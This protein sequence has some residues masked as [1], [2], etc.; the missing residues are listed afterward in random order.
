[1]GKSTVAQMLSDMGCAVVD[2]D[3]LARQVVQPG[4]LAL[5][6]I[7]QAFGADCLD[8]R[9]QLRRDHLARLVF[10]DA[11]ARRRLEEILH[12]RIRGLWRGQVEAWRAVGRPAAVVVIPLLFETQAA[13]E[14]DV[15]L[16]VACTS[17]SQRERL[18][19][20]GWDPLEAE[21]RLRAQ[22]PVEQKIARSGFVVWT[23]GGVAVTREQVGR[24]LRQLGLHS[25]SPSARICT[26]KSVP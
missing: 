4:A 9:G 17:G 23:E 20:R 13:T 24:I 21:A 8:A 14:F 18:A 12:P 19:G 15:V 7:V 1:M 6:E 5:A 10:S 22:W 3:L 16:C 2:T 26:E 25:L 11:A